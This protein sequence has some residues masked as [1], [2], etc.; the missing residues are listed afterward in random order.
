MESL[1]VS[2]LLHRLIDIAERVMSRA[3]L[4]TGLAAELREL[5]Q[6]VDTLAAKPVDG[7]RYVG[8]WE[9]MLATALHNIDLAGDR[10]EATGWKQVAGVLL[11][12]VREHYRQAV[13]AMR[14][15]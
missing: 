15:A 14:A 13:D 12:M 5:R 6:A 3:T 4:Y 7:P 11:P 8:E 1:P 2:S 9:R 10:A